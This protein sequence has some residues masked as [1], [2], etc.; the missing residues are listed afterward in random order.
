MAWVNSGG[1]VY[2]TSG[3]VGIGTSSPSVLLD[4][5][6]G[7]AWF[8]DASQG[9]RVEQYDHLGKAFMRVLSDRQ[10]MASSVREIA[11]HTNPDSG[12]DYA[13]VYIGRVD[14]VS[15][16]LLN[17]IP[18][19]KFGG[20][21]SRFETLGL[22][23]ADYEN[24]ANLAL[25]RAREVESPG[26][27]PDVYTDSGSPRGCLSG[28]RV[29]II[30]WQPYDGTDYSSGGGNG[31]IAAISAETTENADR[32]A[33]GGQLSF[34]TG[35][36]GSLECVQRWLLL[37]TGSLIPF[38]DITYDLGATG[39][40]VRAGYFGQVAA[41]TVFVEIDA[42]TNQLA[43]PT[44][45]VGGVRLYA[46]YPGLSVRGI[47]AP[48]PS[49]PCYLT[50]V[51]VSSEAVTFVHNSGSASAQDRLALGGSDRTLDSGGGV[52]FLYDANSTIWRV[53]GCF[54]FT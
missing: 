9:L 47:A 52:H 30:Y 54:L 14:Y 39:A 41:R 22:Y 4:V 24:P 17:R 29:G 43:V 7:S 1:D 37:N 21:T 2:I 33:R 42:D 18:S 51:N 19:A 20:T 35:A 40:Y 10:G 15:G 3:N 38:D 5:Q 34:W 26:D 36:N 11:I 12:G 16:A 27:P 13:D 28:T 45:G 31:R 50:I 23:L 6:G 46:D 44:S 25:R 8:G 53:A 49:I 32:E 48:S